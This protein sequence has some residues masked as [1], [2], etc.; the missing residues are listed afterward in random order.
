MEEKFV[1]LN[2]INNLIAKL[3]ERMPLSLGE[4]K[5][6]NRFINNGINNMKEKELHFDYQNTIDI[7]IV[8]LEEK[9]ILET[10]SPRE[11]GQLS[12]YRNVIKKR[13]EK[14]QGIINQ[15]EDK[16]LKL[17]PSNINTTGAVVTVVIIEVT[18]LLGILL[19]IV[20]LVKR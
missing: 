8:Y 1:S 7:Y 10:I 12:E 5:A 9:E 20:A 2:T 17:L 6:L 4:A 15:S 3:Y 16:K 18:L 11:T 14:I 19:G 13:E